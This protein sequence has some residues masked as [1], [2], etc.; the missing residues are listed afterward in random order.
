MRI[1]VI[2]VYARSTDGVTVSFANEAPR[3]PGF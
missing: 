3:S 1:I 2:D